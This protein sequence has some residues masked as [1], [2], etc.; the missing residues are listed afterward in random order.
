MSHGG[1]EEENLEA[2]AWPGFVDILSSVMIMFVFFLMITATAL[3]FHTI[4]FKSKVLSNN[5]KVVSDQ[6]DEKVQD[7]IIENKILK[8]QIQQLSESSAPKTE[9]KDDV[10]QQSAEFV[11][12][13]SQTTETIDNDNTL[14]VFFGEDAISLTKETTDIVKAFM[15]KHIDSAKEITLVSNMQDVNEIELTARKVAVARMLN[16][17]NGILQSKYPS[18]KIKASIVKSDSIKDKADWVKVV[19]GK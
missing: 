9:T 3:Y 4:Q 6:V 8:E 5:A 15:E 2:N 12:S 14:I 7:L 10:L 11:A 19:V 18:N 16:V 13:E 17:R 1:G